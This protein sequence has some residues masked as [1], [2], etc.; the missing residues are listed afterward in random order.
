MATSAP[1]PTDDAR[2]RWRENLRRTLLLLSIW[3][4]VGPV[5]GVLL[6]DRLNRLEVLGTPLGFWIA[7]QGSIYVFIALIFTYAW[8]ADRAERRP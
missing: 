4:L 2:A 6:V 5:C 3:L 8:L 1:D 7:L